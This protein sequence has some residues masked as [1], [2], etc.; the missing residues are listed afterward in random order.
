M[1]KSSIEQFA[2]TKNLHRRTLPKTIPESCLKVATK[3]LHIPNS[4]K[5]QLGSAWGALKGD[6]INVHCIIEA[7]DALPYI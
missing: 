3:L 1:Q 6:S 2:K 7:T 4:F 5:L